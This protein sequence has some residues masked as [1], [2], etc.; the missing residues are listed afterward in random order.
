MG[1]N[2]AHEQALAGTSSRLKLI[3][4][5]KAEMYLKG[6]PRRVR[7][8]LTYES[9]C[10]YHTG[11][12][13]GL[14]RKIGQQYKHLPPDLRAEVLIRTLKHGMRSDTIEAYGYEHPEAETPITKETSAPRWPTQAIRHGRC[15][16]SRRRQAGRIR[17]ER[18]RAACSL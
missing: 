5:E 14:Y 1:R 4:D 16:A 10:D 7:E 13:Y 15:E 12:I 8:W 6:L 9:H 2:I 18:Q 11:D 17:Q 3:T